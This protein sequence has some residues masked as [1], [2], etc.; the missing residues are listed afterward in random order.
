M[1]TGCTPDC[2][3]F[4]HYGCPTAAVTAAAEA[5]ARRVVQPPCDEDPD[6]K[7]DADALAA[8]DG[9]M[10]IHAESLRIGRKVADPDDVATA[11]ARSLP[12]VYDAE[13]LARMLVAA[14]IRLG[15]EWNERTAS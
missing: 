2:E 7:A 10:A 14:M 9:M 5:R 15:D 3:P 4:A 6:A 1:S 11:M 13:E 12:G 8:S